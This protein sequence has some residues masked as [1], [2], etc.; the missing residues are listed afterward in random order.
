M[1]TTILKERLLRLMP[2][3]RA[4]KQGKGVIMLFDKDIGEIVKISC[5]NSDDSTLQLVHPALIV[6]R[7]ILAR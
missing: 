1:N 3:L 4:Q 7:Y 2:D 5:S 6:R